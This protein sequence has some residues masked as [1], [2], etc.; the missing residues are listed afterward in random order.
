MGI[1]SEQLRVIEALNPVYN[2]LTSVFDVPAE[3]FEAA[4]TAEKQIRD[5]EADTDLDDAALRHLVDVYKKVFHTHAGREFPQ[6]PHEQLR[7]AVQAVFRSWNVE[8][9]VVYRRA[10]GPGW[11]PPTALS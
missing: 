3:E 2:A 4:L 8:R 6:A 11:T 7:L 1:L 9:A 10:G 5:A